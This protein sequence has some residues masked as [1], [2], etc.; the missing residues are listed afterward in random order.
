MRLTLITKLLP[1]RR[2]STLTDEL[3]ILTGE[4]SEADWAAWERKF[5]PTPRH[6]KRGPSGAPANPPQNDGGNMAD[7]A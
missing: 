7:A 3:R 2:R 1:W 4:I 5:G 6:D